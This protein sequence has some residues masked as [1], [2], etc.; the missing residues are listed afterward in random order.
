MA[1]EASVQEVIRIVNLVWLQGNS[2][3][4]DL[5]EIKARLAVG[6]TEATVNE[7]VRVA[8]ET[9]SRTGEILSKPASVIDPAKLAAALEATGITV[10][11]DEAALAKLLEASLSDDFAAIP[12]AVRNAIVK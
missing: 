9:W 12:G 11:I 7:A 10:R 2:T 1:E 3:L 8:N 6:A 5:A 4:A